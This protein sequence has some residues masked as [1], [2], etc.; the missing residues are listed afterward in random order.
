M[1]SAHM[2]QL[3]SLMLLVIG[4]ILIIK[5]TNENEKICNN[6]IYCVLCLVLCAVTKKTH[7]AAG[8]STGLPSAFL[9][10]TGPSAEPKWAKARKTRAFLGYWLCALVPI[11]LSGIPLSSMWYLALKFE[12]D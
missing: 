8:F 6:L 1:S 4:K 12:M 9:V 10:I 2:R 5:R 3:P 7:E 11:Q